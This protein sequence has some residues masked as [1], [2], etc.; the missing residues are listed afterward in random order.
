MLP[1]VGLAYRLAVTGVPR[2][3]LPNDAVE[4]AELVY[5]VSE[6]VPSLLSDLGAGGAK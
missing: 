4:A 2:V 5:E 3:S 6:L 1:D